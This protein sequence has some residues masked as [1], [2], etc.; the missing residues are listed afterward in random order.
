VFFADIPYDIQLKKE[1]YYQTVFYLIF[2]LI[3][4]RVDAEVRLVL[5]KAEG[6]SR[7]RIDG[8]VELPD[9]VFLFEFKL[10]GSGAEALQQIKDMEYFTRYRL[11]GKTLQL[12]G[13]NFAMEKRGIAG[14]VSEQVG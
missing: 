10:D 13:V 3:G 11:K 9:R 1:K 6:T 5:S 7:G 4:L 12:V 8:V 14:W 2:K